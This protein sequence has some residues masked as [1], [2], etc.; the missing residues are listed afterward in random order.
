MTAH[1]RNASTAARA[2]RAAPA[3]LALVLL[4]LPR[5]EA[6][7]ALASAA[8]SVF[9]AV[10]FVCAAA[11]LPGRFAR[12]APL[13]A[14]GCGGS[15]PGAL[16][17]PA[18]ALCW[19]AFGPALTLARA[20]TALGLAVLARRTRR[21]TRA[22]AGCAQAPDPL[23]ELAGIGCAAFAGALVEA[24][25]PALRG[26][27]APAALLAGLLA[28]GLL[29]CATAGV[30]LA[31]GLR[32][33]APAVAAGLLAGAGIVR[34]SLPIRPCGAR[35]DGRPAA[36]LLL[37]ACLWLAFG[38]ARGFL[39]PRL[40]WLAPAGALG[41]VCLLRGV[42]TRLRP[43][44]LLPL[45]LLAALTFGSPPPGERAATL[46]LG[47][48]PGAALDF[49]G[50][51]GPGGRSVRRAAILCCRADAHVLEVPLEVPLAL[52]AGRWVRVTGTMESTPAGLRLGRIRA[53][54]VA[55]PRDPFAYL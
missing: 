26:M 38:D 24:A 15:L 7:A 50:R 23:A 43:A 27:W 20:A 17:L 48:Y 37:G 33:S 3:A 47:L 11:V 51:V 13:L 39:N 29:P 35:R 54:A 42:S 5:G 2:G 45:A 46:P 19:L 18:L 25:L 4:A 8:A 28:G 52:P 22:P 31:A 49:T 12:L 14:C 1:V 32:P 36:A 34:L 21:R 10:P 9:E 30:S 44:A 55:P 6:H 40:A 16:S 53:A 41:S